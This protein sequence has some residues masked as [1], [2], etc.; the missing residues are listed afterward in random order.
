MEGLRVVGDP[1]ELAVK[2]EAQGADEILYLDITAS[3][4]GYP[5]SLDTIRQ[6]STDLYI[7]LTVGG[8]IRTLDDVQA[9]LR[10]GADKVA[11]NTAAIQR[12]AFIGEIALAFGSQAVVVSI[13]AK[14]RGLGWQAYALGG[15]EPMGAW[16]PLEWAQ[17]AVEEGAGEILLTSVDQDGTQGGFDWELLHRMP[18][19]SVPLVLSGGAGSPE[20]CLRAVQGGADAVAIGAMLHHGKATI[21]DIKGVF[22]LHHVAV[23]LDA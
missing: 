23:R 1:Y 20:D 13:E 12:P 17:V 8:G 7:P 19:L 18:S 15:R 11:I 4:Y 6:L 21:G 3:L 22:H 9:V 2:Y 14:R 5:T 16:S 10:A